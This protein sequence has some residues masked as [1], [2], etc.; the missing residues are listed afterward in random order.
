M[1]K[2]KG[3]ISERIEFLLVKR[4][5][6][7]QLM[8]SR[9][10]A[11]CSPLRWAILEESLNSLV[12]NLIEMGT[13]HLEKYETGSKA[14][15]RENWSYWV[16]VDAVRL[17]DLIPSLPKVTDRVKV[18]DT[19]LESLFAKE[20]NLAD[21][22]MH[23][24]ETLLASGRL[25]HPLYLTKKFGSYFFFGDIVHQ[26]ALTRLF[27]LLL[28]AP[29]FFEGLPSTV[30][31][32]GAVWLPVLRLAFLELP[33]MSEELAYAYRSSL[34]LVGNINHTKSSLP[35]DWIA[36][37]F[38]AFHSLSE[39]VDIGISETTTHRIVCTL[40]V[41]TLNNQI[42]IEEWLHYSTKLAVVPIIELYEHRKDLQSDIVEYLSN[43]AIDYSL[44]SPKEQQKL[45]T[46]LSEFQTN[47]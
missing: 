29:P 5:F 10:S 3:L 9:T 25:D 13:L 46:I 36:N 35:S 17:Y 37:H 27:H 38:D 34:V 7:W 12:E 44:L 31:L 28:G 8:V 39:G 11:T 1:A 19:E 43:I 22:I 32:F 42:H 6:L 23:D 20:I 14:T 45:R 2:F 15:D 40:I 21:P 47:L 16:G 33:P 26:S 30:P 24:F 18:T 41:H 4:S